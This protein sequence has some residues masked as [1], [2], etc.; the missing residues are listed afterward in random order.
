MIGEKRKEAASLTEKHA[1]T[2]L[3]ADRP[4]GLEWFIDRYTPYVSAVVRNILG[5][6]MTEQDIEETVSDTFVTLWRSREKIRPG[7]AKG[8]LGAIARSRALNRLRLAGSDLALEEDILSLPEAG[9]EALAEG[10]ERDE[11]VRRAVQSLTEPDREIFVR[12]YY[13][14]Q[15]AADVAALLGMTPEAVRQRL[16]RGRDRLRTVLTEGGNGYDRDDQ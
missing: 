1:L 8:Y 7:Q 14:G 12:H 15:S 16:K 2:L 13:Y 10:R 9:P 5:R 11:A 4:G 3:R 6:A